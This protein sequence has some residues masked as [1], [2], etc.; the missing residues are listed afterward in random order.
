MNQ[1]PQLLSEDE[2]NKAFERAKQKV[3][4]LEITDE[5]RLCQI[6]NHYKTWFIHLTIEDFE[7]MSYDEIEKLVYDYKGNKNLYEQK[8]KEKGFNGKYIQR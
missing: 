7:G 8:T 1:K 3:K 2:K 4:E 6:H 5:K